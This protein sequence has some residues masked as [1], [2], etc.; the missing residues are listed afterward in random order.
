ML[1]NARRRGTGMHRKHKPTHFTGKCGGSWKGGKCQPCLPPQ[2]LHPR[3]PQQQHRLLNA[4]TS[5]ACKPTCL[6]SHGITQMCNYISTGALEEQTY[7]L[8]TQSAQCTVTARCLH[9]IISLVT[10]RKVVSV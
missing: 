4:V 8:L 10:N 5:R 6:F 9:N 3:A 7:P 1:L 2:E